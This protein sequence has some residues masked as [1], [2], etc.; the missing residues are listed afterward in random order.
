MHRARRFL[1]ITYG[2]VRF[3]CNMDSLSNHSSM[4]SS[5]SNATNSFCMPITNTRSER[6]GDADNFRNSN[7]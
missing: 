3:V 7:A 6:I 1:L 4:I 2:Y 5:D